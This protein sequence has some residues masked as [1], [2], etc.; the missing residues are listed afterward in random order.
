MYCDYCVVIRECVLSWAQVKVGEKSAS[1][2][3]FWSGGQNGVMAK[4]SGEKDKKKAQ[5]LER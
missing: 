4:A 3:T 5:I 1:M 2:M